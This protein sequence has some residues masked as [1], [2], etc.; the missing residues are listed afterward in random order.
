MSSLC[1]SY[2]A[3]SAI[4]VALW[5]WLGL[6]YHWLFFTRINP[7][8]FVFAAVSLAGALAFFWRGIFCRKLRFEHPV[9]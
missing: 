1:R 5:A 3:V 8:A 9:R 2:N 6:V 7:L 4:L